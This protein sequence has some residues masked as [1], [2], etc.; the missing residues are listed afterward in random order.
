[1]GNPVKGFR[2]VYEH[3]RLNLSVIMG[4][5][6]AIQGDPHVGNAEHLRDE[7]TAGWRK[8]QIAL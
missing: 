5:T 8:K 3:G 6:G 1:M 7:T 2:K 4:F